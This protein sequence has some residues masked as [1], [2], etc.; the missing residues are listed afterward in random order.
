MAELFNYVSDNTPFTHFC[1][2]FNCIF[3]ADRKQLAMLYQQ[4]GAADCTRDKAVKFRDP[5]LTCCR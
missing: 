2:V 3:A 4:V 5:R 1:A